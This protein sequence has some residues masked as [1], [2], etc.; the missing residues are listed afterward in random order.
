MPVFWLIQIMNLIFSTGFFNKY[1]H[2]SW[3][4]EPK[5]I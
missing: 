4:T 3:S 1:S 2:L 5:W